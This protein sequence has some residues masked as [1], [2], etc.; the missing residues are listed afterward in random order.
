MDDGVTA[1]PTDA[2]IPAVSA[3][4]S[5]AAAS[6]VFAS[7]RDR[8]R[9]TLVIARAGES[10]CLT[11][12]SSKTGRVVH[13]SESSVAVFGRSR[14]GGKWW[15]GLALSVPR[16]RGLDASSGRPPFSIPHF[17]SHDPDA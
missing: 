13:L 11:A 17:G 1:S 14:R 3:R 15:Q 9:L 16:G 5:L 10:S 6:S 8:P 7:R 2:A 12:M 4:P